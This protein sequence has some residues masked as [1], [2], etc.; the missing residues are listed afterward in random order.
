MRKKSIC[1]YIYLSVT[2][3]RFQ[4]C[5]NIFD[6]EHKLYIMFRKEQALNS[7]EVESQLLLIYRYSNFYVSPA[8]WQRRSVHGPIWIVWTL[9]DWMSWIIK[10]YMDHTKKNTCRNADVVMPCP[11]IK[12]AIINKLDKK[13]SFRKKIQRF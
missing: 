4:N 3:L 11:N 5:I 1:T 2:K 10:T 12:V 7:S 6:L 8:H 9:G 13:K